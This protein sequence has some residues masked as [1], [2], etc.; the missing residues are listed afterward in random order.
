MP[1][2]AYWATYSGS[3]G[4]TG[5]RLTGVPAEGAGCAAAAACGTVR[6]DTGIVEAG[7]VCG[8]TSVCAA[9]AGV[10]AGVAAGAADA[11]G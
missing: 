6:A 5:T 9:A 11:T 3:A 2:S 7:E 4:T 1:P 10:P 8:D